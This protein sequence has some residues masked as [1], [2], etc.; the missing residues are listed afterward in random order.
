MRY[1]PMGRERE[2]GKQEIARR[3]NYFIDVPLLP[4]GAVLLLPLFGCSGDSGEEAAALRILFTGETCGELEACDCGGLP[5]GGI[6]HRGGYIEAQAGPFLL[7]DVG[8]IGNGAREFELLRAE[9]VL[10]G[11]KGMGYRA[12]NVGE[13]EAWAGLEGI[14]R[15]ARIGVPLVSANVVDA[16]GRPAAE[17]SVAADLGGVRVAVTGVLASTASPGPGLRIEPPAEAAARLVPELSREGLVVILADL[18][19]E[20]VRE[21]A[22]ACPEAAAILFRGRGDSRPPERI[23]RT[24]AVSVSGEGRYIGS[25]GLPV[26]GRRAAGEPDWS[27]V[28]VDAR[29]PA[30][31]SVASA[32]IGGYKEAVRGKVFDVRQAA[33]GWARIAPSPVEP[34][35]GH[36]GSEACR[37]CHPRAYRAWSASAHGRS[38]ESLVRMG[39]E[40]SPECI[41]CHVTGYGAPDGYSSRADTPHL[42]NVGCEACHGPGKAL[43]GGRCRGLARRGGEDACRR[44][45]DGKHHPGFVFAREMEAVAHQPGEG[46]GGRGG[47]REEGR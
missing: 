17:R 11:M 43:L 12:A 32:A 22:G 3:A 37:D 46:D 7:V 18:D 34:G 29:L 2:A 5:A 23:G 8:C 14:R 6:H 10:R 25:L 4:A 27:P 35:N 45:H 41:V 31:P 28:L 19:L 24:W 40:W 26:P 1:I 20:G 44:C 36:A 47:K 30:S 15:L 16:G 9:A 33:P 38:M 13:H 21:L 39:Y 42:G